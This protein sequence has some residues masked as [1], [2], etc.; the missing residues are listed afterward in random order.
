M[1]SDVLE[2]RNLQIDV[3]GFAVVVATVDLLLALTANGDQ[4]SEFVQK[5]GSRCGQNPRTT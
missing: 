4:D 5:L 3:N 1:L 2:Y